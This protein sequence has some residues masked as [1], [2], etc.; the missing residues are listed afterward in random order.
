MTLE[1]SQAKWA[2]HD[3]KLDS[4]IR[5]NQ[6]LLSEKSLNGAR[7]ALRRAK[8]SALLSAIT[9]WLIIPLM[10]LFF[11][12]NHDEAKF[13]LP[14]A[15]IDLYFIAAM[16]AHIQQVR[17]LALINYGDSVTVIQKQIG[18]VVAMRIRLARWIAM[19]MVLLWVPIAIVAAKG[20]FE[21]DLYSLAPGWLIANLLFGFAWMALVV[22]LSKRIAARRESPRVQR[23]VRD[24]AGD[25]LSAAS[26]FLAG[27]AEFEDEERTTSVSANR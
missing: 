2:Q 26:A 9:T 14:A 11:I 19:S 23:L 15:V 21:W 7:T 25:S 27:L 12:K 18:A 22:W 10:A 16:I 1:E 4:L 5:L 13:V 6:E 8:L 24:I 17:A 3:Q 20:V